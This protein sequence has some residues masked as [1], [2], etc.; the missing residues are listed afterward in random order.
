MSWSGPVSRFGLHGGLSGQSCGHSVYQGGGQEL[1]PCCRDKRPW[2]EERNGS[3][4]EEPLLEG[5][6][7]M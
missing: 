4:R 2:V 6:S 5:V 1:F 3:I 7:S